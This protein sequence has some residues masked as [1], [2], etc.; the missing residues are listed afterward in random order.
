VREDGINSGARNVGRFFL[1]LIP[2]ALG[3]GFAVW[4]GVYTALHE[5]RREAQQERRAS[6]YT[7]AAEAPKSK[8]KVQALSKSCVHITHVDVDGDALWLY[9]RND[10]HEDISYGIDWHWELVSPNGTIVKQGY[11]NAGNC[12][13]P[14]SAGSSAECKPYDYAI[15]ERAETLRVWMTK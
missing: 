9:G 6:Q 15:D 13:V 4:L 10:C 8:L 2:W 7:G 1:A 11:V 3:F 14:S 5:I 12:P